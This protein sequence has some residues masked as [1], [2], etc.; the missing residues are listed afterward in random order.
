MARFWDRRAREDPWYFVDTRLDYRRPDLE[1]F[2]ASGESDLDALLGALGVEVPPAGSV[3]EIGCGVGRMTRALAARAAEVVALDVSRRMLELAR[4]HN[5][6]LENVTWLLGDGRS[7]AGVGDASAGACLSYVVFQH[8]PDPALT[9]GY[10]RE[11]GRVLRPGGW[12]AFQVSND[13][14]VHR[15]PGP[16][17]RLRRRA[18]SL[19]GRAPRGQDDP[20]WRGSA[21]D[22]DEL[23]RVAAEAGLSL[24][25]VLHPGTQYCLV[26]ARAGGPPGEPG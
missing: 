19:L 25:R 10:V 16:P 3:V 2:W 8:L 13:P 26:L 14:E 1:R 23:G 6:G 11:I 18:A 24:E 21:V 20:A 12:A 7:L 15:P 22:L 9:L 5:R 4:E 17:A